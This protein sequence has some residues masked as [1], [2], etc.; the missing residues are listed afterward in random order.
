MIAWWLDGTLVW[1]LLWLGGDLMPGLATVDA[2]VARKI[3]IQPVKGS[4]GA[5]IADEGY[6]PSPINIALKLWLKAHWL[7]WQRVLPAI[8][9]RQIG[10]LRRPLEIWHPAAEVLGIE[11]IYVTKI[12]SP[13][14]EGGKDPRIIPIEA[15]QWF[16]A[17]KPAKTSSK[18]AKTPKV[19]AVNSSDFDVNSPADSGAPALNI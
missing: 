5:T 17:P 1:D 7:E 2:E 16:P 12:G 10:G 3:D 8:H 14:G 15:I 11:T 19:G 18:A 6:I 4:D 9:P 13:R